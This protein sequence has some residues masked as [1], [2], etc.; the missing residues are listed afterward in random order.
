[1]GAVHVLQH[2]MYSIQLYGALL[3]L[4]DHVHV[5]DAIIYVAMCLNTC[6][7]Q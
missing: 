2:V 1:M 3:L 6:M 5:K 7:C 4:Q